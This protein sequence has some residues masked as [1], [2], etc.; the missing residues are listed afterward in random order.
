[1]VREG[2]CS[3]PK[4]VRASTTT[5][6]VPV[7]KRF[8]WEAF[9]DK[10]KSLGVPTSSLIMDLVDQFLLMQDL[11]DVKDVKRLL[12]IYKQLPADVKKKAL[13]ILRKG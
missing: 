5:I 10:A 8:I 7:D 9:K 4:D 2:R 12:K 11:E 13:A 6:Y 3:V 1:V